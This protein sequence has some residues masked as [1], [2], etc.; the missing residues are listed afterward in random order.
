MT[1]HG[2]VY[3]GKR[4]SW[5]PLSPPNAL[6]KIPRYSATGT[7][8]FKRVLSIAPVWQTPFEQQMVERASPFSDT[9]HAIHTCYKLRPGVST[10]QLN[11]LEALVP[12]VSFTRQFLIVQLLCP[13][14]G[15]YCRHIS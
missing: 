6:N 7:L 12:V 13:W 1:R 15:G 3:L 10:M 4:C 5:D 14:Y 8:R 9:A 11:S 2:P